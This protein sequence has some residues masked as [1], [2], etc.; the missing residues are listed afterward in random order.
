[1]T[2]SNVRQQ[3]RHATILTVA[4]AVVPIGILAIAITA[5]SWWDGLLVAGSL[6]VPLLLLGRWAP[7]GSPDGS[8]L[9]MI[10]AAASWALSAGLG[11][12]PLAVFAFSLAGAMILT[13]LPRRRVIAVLGFCAVASTLGS[14]VFLTRPFTLASAA[15]YLLI[16]AATTLLICAVMAL[17]EWYSGILIALERAKS[18]EAEL[19]VARERIR[20]AGDLHDIHGHTLHVI[21][22]KTALAEQ[23]AGSD[24]TSAKR[25][26]AEV[27]HLI[28]DTIDRTQDLVHA[29]RR[30]NF[31]V[32][33]E[34]AKNLL[35]AAG[36]TVTVTTI[37][38]VN[39]AVGSLLAQVLRE[40]TTNI[41]RHAHS[42]RTTITI[43]AH[44]IDI[45]NDGAAAEPLPPLGGLG[46][47]R[48]RIEDVGGT[49]DL[50]REA[51]EFRTR[52]AI[53]S[54]DQITS[55]SEHAP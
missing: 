52:A 26:L 20:F 48:R 27:Q 11:G 10:L 39:G 34:N 22:L 37:D 7:D 15:H 44:R 45:I 19:A 23:I 49:L 42:T 16:P 8:I 43:N 13:R 31:T 50:S 47:L 30:L 46:A 6:L 55:V 28:A 32:E 36:V 51:G 1:M 38:S 9:I 18:V 4:I 40:T 17:V 41:L 29:R 54:P 3:I 33:S 14:L 25:E 24:P 12:S 53:P 21:K 5:T 2:D 35:E